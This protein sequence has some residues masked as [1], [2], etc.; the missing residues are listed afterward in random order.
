MAAQ[1]AAQAKELERELARIDGQLREEAAGVSVS[2]FVDEV[3]QC[4]ADELSAERARVADRIVLLEERIR[5]L[6]ALQATEDSELRRMD[7][8]PRA[9]EAA[10]QAQQLLAVMQQQVQ[11]YVHLRLAARLLREQIERYR[12]EN[13][14]PILLRASELFA[15]LTGRSFV[16]LQADYDDKDQPVVVGCRPNGSRLGV[17]AMSAGSRDQLYLALRLATLEHHIERHEPLPFIVDDILINF[18]DQRSAATLKEL[19]VL[20]TKTQV[21]MFT[22]HRRVCELAAELPSS[23]EVFVHELGADHGASN[24]GSPQ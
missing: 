7:G 14:H 15:K 8:N 3:A 12:A 10:E 13:Q 19:A 6:I 2:E 22:H 9:A 20:A 21:I 23:A 1:R 17:G 16:A 11:R 18:D 4:D 5:D 24:D